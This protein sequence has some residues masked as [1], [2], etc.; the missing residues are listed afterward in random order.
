[1]VEPQPERLKLLVVYEKFVVKSKIIKC[2]HT[3]A[4]EYQYYPEILS[5]T[6]VNHKGST[7]IVKDK[8]IKLREK[9]CSDY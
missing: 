4:L 6:D 2:F 1:M 5:R 7:I 8:S 3:Y 9:N